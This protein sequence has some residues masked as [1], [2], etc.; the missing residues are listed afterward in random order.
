MKSCNKN[1]AADDDKYDLIMMMAVTKCY[2]NVDD[3]DNDIIDD[4]SNAVAADDDNDENSN[5]ATDDKC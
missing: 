2:E 3:A 4:N 5:A 1:A